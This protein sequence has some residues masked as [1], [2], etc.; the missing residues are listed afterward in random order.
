[1]EAITQIT[2]LLSSLNAIITL[3]DT[4][5]LIEDEVVRSKKCSFR[6]VHKSHPHHV[7]HYMH[8]KN[9]TSQNN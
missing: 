4:P 6:G 2:L 5:I 1:M 8:I 9:M 7:A 3:I